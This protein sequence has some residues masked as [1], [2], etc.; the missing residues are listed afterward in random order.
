MGRGL[1]Q[2]HTWLRV[3]TAGWRSPVRWPYRGLTDVINYVTAV[4]L[5]S[6]E[7][8]ARDGF[9]KKLKEAKRPRRILQVLAGALVVALIQAVAEKSSNISAVFKTWWSI[10]KRVAEPAA[11]IFGTLIALATLYKLLKLLAKL[12]F[13]GNDAVDESVRGWIL[14]TFFVLA[15]W[16]V[17][18]LIYWQH[19][20]VDLPYVYASLGL[21]GYETATAVA[22]AKI[23]D[24]LGGH[25]KPAIEGH[26]KTGQ[27]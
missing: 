14:G 13:T 12:T 10:A 19:L 11:E 23:P 6:W 4:S 7:R 22:A 26:L 17:Y 20:L 27:R 5:E 16:P 3:W 21:K 2:A 9:M 25:P 8:V 18:L 24:R 15:V 1:P